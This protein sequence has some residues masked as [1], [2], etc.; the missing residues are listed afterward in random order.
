MSALIRILILSDQGSSPSPSVYLHFFLT[1]SIDTL[2]IRASTCDLWR[3]T[4]QSTATFKPVKCAITIL[5]YS[6][7]CQLND[8]CQN[9][10]VSFSPSN[11]NYFILT[12]RQGAHLLCVPDVILDNVPYIILESDNYFS[13]HL[14]KP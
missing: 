5:C 8:H 14:L 11:F 7:T 9:E 10:I 12:N 3:N 4:I 2:D 6:C 1:P 13:Y